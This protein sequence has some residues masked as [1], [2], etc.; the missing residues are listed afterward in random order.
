MFFIDNITIQ[1]LLDPLSTVVVMD[2]SIKNQ[3]AILI[4]H[5]H[6]HN[7]PVI[8]TLHYVVNVTSAK[9]K[10]FTIRCGIN[11]ATC[12]PNISQIIVITDSI[13]AVKRIFDSSSH[14]YQLHSAS[15]LQE[16]REFFKKGNNNLIKFWDCRSNQR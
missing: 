11:Q 1:V 14:L 4:P 13:H 9:A 5:I 15:I 6:S 8:K 10:L 7:N 16:L 12:L 2:I 3:V